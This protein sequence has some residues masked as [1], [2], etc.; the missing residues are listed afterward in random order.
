[1]DTGDEELDQELA[2]YIR[3]TTGF[4]DYVMY[5]VGF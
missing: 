1:V 3:V 4:R 2:G 5:K